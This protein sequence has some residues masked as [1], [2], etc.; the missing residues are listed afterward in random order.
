[1]AMRLETPSRIWA[2]IESAQDEELPSLPSMPGFEDSAFPDES[3]GVSVQHSAYYPTPN[4]QKPPSTFTPTPR[5]SKIR[6]LSTPLSAGES[7]AR[8]PIYPDRSHSASSSNRSR[9][10]SSD[11]LPEEYLPPPTEDE[12]DLSMS[13]TDALESVSRSGSPNELSQSLNRT[14][15]P[16][17]S[18]KDIY[19]DSHASVRDAVSNEAYISFRARRLIQY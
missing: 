4:K 10:L 14:P 12:E 6:A 17:K 16:H 8:A 18:L 11:S 2:R 19:N 7:T 5:P 1:M 3:E 15:A 9:E 13:L